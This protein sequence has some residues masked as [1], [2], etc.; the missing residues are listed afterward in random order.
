MS[1]PNDS[2]RDRL[3][4]HPLPEVMA[5]RALRHQ[6]H[7]SL[8]ELGDAR[9]QAPESEK[10][11]RLLHLEQQVSPP[12]RPRRPWPRRRSEPTAESRPLH[13]SV[14]AVSAERR[15]RRRWRVV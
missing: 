10:S 3:A 9:L 7:L 15:D 12:V 1:D 14:S 11:E 13:P 8:Y 4:Q 6:I 2:Q 5:Q